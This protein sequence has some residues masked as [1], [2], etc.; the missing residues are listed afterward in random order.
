MPIIPTVIFPYG[1]RI[2]KNQQSLNEPPRPKNCDVDCDFPLKVHKSIY[3]PKL[4]DC[5]C[6]RTDGKKLPLDFIVDFPY[7]TCESQYRSFINARLSHNRFCCC[8][9]FDTILKEDCERRG[10]VWNSVNSYTVDAGDIEKVGY[11]NIRSSCNCDCDERS[12]DRYYIDELSCPAGKWNEN[13]CSCDCDSVRECPEPYIHVDNCLCGCDPNII[14][15]DGCETLANGRD[16]YF[17]Y[18]TCQCEYPC[19]PG[20]IASACYKDG[21]Y[22]QA[23]I[24]CIEPCKENEY[25]SP[26]DGTNSRHCCPIG[27]FW[28]YDIRSKLGECIPCTID[29]YPDCGGGPPAD[30]RRVNPLTCSCCPDGHIWNESLQKCVCEF[31]RTPDYLDYESFPANECVSPRIITDDCVCDCPEGFVWHNNDCVRIEDR[32]PEPGGNPLHTRFDFYDGR[33]E[34]PIDTSGRFNNK[35]ICSDYARVLNTETCECDCPNNMEP[36]ENSK[37]PYDYCICRDGYVPAYND[38]FSLRFT[39][40]LLGCV[41]CGYIHGDN[42][43]YDT[44][45]FEEC[46]CADGFIFKKINIS[47]VSLYETKIDVP[48]VECSQY[49]E[50]AVWDDESSECICKEGYIKVR[51]LHDFDD[52][53]DLND[54][55]GPDSLKPVSGLSSAIFPWKCEKYFD[56][57]TTETPTVMPTPY[58]S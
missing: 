17:D 48:C 15:K 5:K 35:S 46:R 52:E 31:V 33:C 40:P 36:L 24:S 6:V 4:R 32:C 34:C 57:P 20:S 37:D 47:N 45:V 44:A 1:T 28:K 22:S 42:A 56:F 12:T 19:P 41:T 39:D 2:F 30:L 21:P 38:L 23:V 27:S 8:G 51:E 10:F 43:I 25:L 26:Y 49:T 58:P 3:D 14:P 9:C 53:T 13:T 55:F 18:G 7:P 16:G 50:N 29:E 54:G 11:P